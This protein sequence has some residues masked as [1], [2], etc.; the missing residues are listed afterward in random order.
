MGRWCSD[1]YRL[2]T[3]LTKERLSELSEKM[4]EA[5]TT[6]F[7][8][9][10]RGFFGTVLDVEPVEKASEGPAAETDESAY[11]GMEQARETAS[12]LS[13]ERGQRF[14]QHFR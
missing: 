5:T 1:C 14:G 9:G 3:R 8:N 11:L 12:F 2:C 6:Q 4:G 13:S 10:S 7:V